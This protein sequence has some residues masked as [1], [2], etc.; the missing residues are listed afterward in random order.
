MRTTRARIK[1]EQRFTVRVERSIARSPK[2]YR[3]WISPN[4]NQA[5]EFPSSKEMADCFINGQCQ[6]G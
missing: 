4:A 3:R 5:I 1:V 2:T 6:P